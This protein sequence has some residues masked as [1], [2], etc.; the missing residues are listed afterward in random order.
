MSTVC[1]LVGSAAISGGSYVIIQH[2]AAMVQSGYKVTLA[3]QEPF[4]TETLRWHDQLPT[5]RCIPFVQA[6][7]EDFDLVVATWWKTALELPAFKAKRHGYFVQSIESRF[8]P[9]TEGPLRALINATYSLPVSFVTEA[10]WIQEELSRSYWQS[11]ALVRNG[12]RKDVYNTDGAAIS[13]ERPGGLRVLVEG[14]FGVRFKNTALGIKLSRE[15]GIRDIWL[16][17][18]SPVSNIPRVSR[19]FSRVPMMETGPIYRSC[20]VLVKLSTVEG[21]FGPPLE[22]FH[23][24]GTAVVFDVTGHDEYIRDGFNACVVRR[25]SCDGV[26]SALRQLRDSAEELGGL[27]RGALET[28]SGWPSWEQSS[29]LFV[30]WVRGVLAGPETN[31]EACS[32]IIA[33]AWRQ[34]ETDEKERLRRNPMIVRRYKLSAL[35]AKLPPV[36]LRGMKQ[37][38]AIGEV[39]FGP[40]VVR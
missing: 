24:G 12:I 33:E 31:I 11:P 9:D 5:L 26:V 32:R 25:R 21:M 39:L 15:A 27:R 40:R 35:A 30:E 1:I 3:I 34:Y 14:H 28:A 29:P 7:D 19:V 37:A 8:Y 4:T 22:M 6:L 16:L 13:D 10:A 36:I 17:T 38:E 20:D 23:C 2:A 18:G